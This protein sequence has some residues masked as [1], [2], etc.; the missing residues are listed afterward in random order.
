MI[1]EPREDAAPDLL[2]TEDTPSP[3]SAIS[4][5]KASSTETMEIDSRPSFPHHLGYSHGLHGQPLDHDQR[6]RQALQHI[7]INRH[8]ATAPPSSMSMHSPIPSPVQ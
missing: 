8:S 7:E 3:S 2:T 6:Q 4:T 5:P 1:V